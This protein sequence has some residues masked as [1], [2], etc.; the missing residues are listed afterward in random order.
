M[1]KDLAKIAKDRKIKYF[2][3]SF[4]DMFGSL[5]AKLVPASGTCAMAAASTVSA[6]K[7]SGSKLRTCDLPQAR[8][9]V[10]NS[11]TMVVR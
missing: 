9:R 11:R 4:V 5:R 3:I 6:T 2:L 10:C 7:S 8:A 1:A